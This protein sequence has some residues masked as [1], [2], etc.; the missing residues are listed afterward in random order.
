MHRL[1][2]GRFT[3]GLG[4]GIDPMVRALNRADVTVYPISLIE[5][6][7]QP[8]FVRHPHPPSSIA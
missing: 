8:P 2:G 5:D 7:N 6:P 3:L 4:R 1:T